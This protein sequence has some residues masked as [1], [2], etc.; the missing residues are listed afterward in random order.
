[1]ALSLAPLKHKFIYDKIRSGEPLILES[2]ANSKVLCT[3]RTFLNRRFRTAGI[4]SV[5]INSSDLIQGELTSIDT[6]SDS[7]V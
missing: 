7:L 5:V 4:S 3:L 2:S 6:T 1:M